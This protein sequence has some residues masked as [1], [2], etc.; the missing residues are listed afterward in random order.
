MAAT[1]SNA[2]KVQHQA[3]EILDQAREVMRQPTADVIESLRDYVHKNPESAALWC[4]GIGF[5]L[6]W[7]LKPW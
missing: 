3:E 7:R 4:L 5:V 1:S 6:G 2:K